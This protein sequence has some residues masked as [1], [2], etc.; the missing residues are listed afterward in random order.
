MNKKNF[1]S[2]REK[3]LQD[4]ANSYEHAR[5]EQRSIYL[6]A[7]DLADLAD[8]YN[9]RQKRDMAFEIAD[10]GLKLHPANTSL[11]IEKAYL[12]L[13]D[14]NTTIAQQIAN[15]IDPSLTVTKILQ[16]QIYIQD[17]KLQKGLQVLDS[18]KD[19]KNI[20][21]MINVAYMFISVNKPDKALEWLSPGIGRYED[22]EPFLSVLA[23]AYYGKGLMKEAEDT[24][25]KLI[26]Q[27]P[28]SAIYWFGLARCYFDQQKYDKA[29]EA[30]D[31]AIISDEEF[32]DAYLMKGNAYFFLQNDEKAMENFEETARLGG[33]SQSFV[34]TFIGLTK[35]A[36]EKW[37]EAYQY[38]QRAIDEYENDALV[39]LSSLY[40]N[41]AFCLRHIGQK[42]KS[43]QYWKKAHEYDPESSE[44][45]LLEGKM[46]LEE[47]QYDKAYDCWRYAIHYTPKA[48]TWYEIGI[49]CMEYGIIKQAKE[50]LEMTKR[51][52]PEFIGINEKLATVYL[53]LKDKENFQK[54]NELC[55]Y[56]ITMEELQ[57]IQD[58]VQ[59]ENKENLILAMKNI[60]DALK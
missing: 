38:L 7:E 18:I 21:T 41:A 19:K 34:N 22:D 33:I 51:M 30:C 57:N 47:S 46:Y 12:Y 26:D 50:A 37:E 23:D 2:G 24:Y 9:V 4:M 42:R 48:S 35:T 10:Y 29:I 32:A 44:V 40:A 53:L 15:Q 13:D 43:T 45:Y 39:T 8:W 31:Y 16:S 27:D 55:Q 25:N 36:Q 58:S 56:P 54:Y 59:K 17:K 49:I 14:N 3:E 52:D 60:L 28:Y 11:M 5:S 6:D 20:D 1:L